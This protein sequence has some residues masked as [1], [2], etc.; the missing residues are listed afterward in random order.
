M[1][2]DNSSRT[3]LSIYWRIKNNVNQIMHKE[4]EVQLFELFEF[5]S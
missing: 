4:E 1:E 3:I 5:L 2:K